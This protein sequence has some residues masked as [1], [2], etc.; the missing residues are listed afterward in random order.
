MVEMSDATSSLS[1]LVPSPIVET[2]TLKTVLRTTIKL[3]DFNYLLWAQAFC[4][5]I[6]AQNKLAHLFQPPPAATDPSYVT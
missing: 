5:F 6:D 4:I 3:N 1:I 2:F